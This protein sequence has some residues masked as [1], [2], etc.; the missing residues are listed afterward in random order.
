MIVIILL[1]CALAAATYLIRRPAVTALDRRLAAV[2]ADIDREVRPATPL[3]A[4]A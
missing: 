2:D 3:A 1:F 4:A